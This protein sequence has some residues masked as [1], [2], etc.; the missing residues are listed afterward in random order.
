[1]QI[2]LFQPTIE[3]EARIL[4]LIEAFSRGKATLGGRHFPEITQ[5]AWGQSL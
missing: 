2:D 1:M 4:L 3:G 5:A